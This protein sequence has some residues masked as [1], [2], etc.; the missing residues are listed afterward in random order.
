MQ[1]LAFDHGT[2]R[3]AGR[4]RKTPWP[5]RCRATS[6]SLRDEKA[7]RFRYG[8]RHRQNSHAVSRLE[9]NVAIGSRRQLATAREDLHEIRLQRPEH[10]VVWS[11][12]DNWHVGE[13]LK[14]ELAGQ[15][16]LRLDV[17]V[18]VPE[19]PAT[20]NPAHRP[21]HPTYRSVPRA[22]RQVRHKSIKTLSAPT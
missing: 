8:L 14:L 13:M 4:S 5:N 20:I 12:S 15:E 18:L 3:R 1:E 6:T 16:L 21:S 22:R 9:A 7:P 19:Q 10:F 17:R 11:G 2:T